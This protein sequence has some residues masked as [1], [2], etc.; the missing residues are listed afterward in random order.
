MNTHL[1]SLCWNEAD[2]LPFFFRHYD[3][4]INRYIIYDDGSTDG[5]IEILKKHPKVEVRNWHRKYPDSYLMSQLHWMNTIWKESRGSADWVVIVDIDEHLFVPQTPMINFLEK[6]KSQ[7]ITQIP[8][9]G[10]Q[11][12]SEEFP[13]QDEHLTQSRTM[14]KPWPDMCKLSIFNPEAIEETNFSG[15]RHTAK[16]IGN[17]NMPNNDELQLFHYKYLNFERT[18]NKQNAQY[19]NVGPLDAST[20]FSYGWSRKELLED[21]NDIIK[22][23][24]EM[25]WPTFKSGMYPYTNRWW[26]LPELIYIT[27]QWIR[28][29]MKF[30]CRPIFMIRRLKIFLA[31]RRHS[32]HPE[33]FG[34]VIDKINQSPIRKKIYQLSMHGMTN[35]NED[36]IV[37]STND[38]DERG[39]LIQCLYS[40]DIDKPQDKNAFQ[41]VIARKK[42]IEEIQEKVFDTFVTSNSTSFDKNA[43]ELAKNSKI[44]LVSR[45]NLIKFISQVKVS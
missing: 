24:M 42:K 22:N 3:P 7:G 10:Y 21:W 23:S 25:S 4:W 8:A 35:K 43:V 14:G 18:F 13:G 38:N 44:K 17:I 45:K 26:R 39:V 6:Y 9:L 12:V 30:V 36:D 31:S 34:Q 41:K 2:I 11:I 33:N 27:S 29:A 40:N 1:Y 32:L 16:P 19:R 15:G 20:M 37:I 5:S 28:R